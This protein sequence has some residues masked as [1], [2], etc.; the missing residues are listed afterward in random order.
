MTRQTT[1]IQNIHAPVYGHVAAGD[2]HVLGAATD[3]PAVP[4]DNPLPIDV[5]QTR[6]RTVR[7]HL[8]REHIGCWLNWPTVITISWL[9][10]A[11]SIALRSL[12]TFTQPDGGIGWWTFALLVLPAAGLV[13]WTL[14]VR[15]IRGY[16]VAELTNEVVILEHEIAMRRRR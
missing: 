9:L 13:F 15:R 16:R 11:A 5:L 14:N 12:A 6:L 1:I 4:A 3:E 8:I 2:I 10:M 7:G